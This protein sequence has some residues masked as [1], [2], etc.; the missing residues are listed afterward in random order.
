MITYSTQ[1]NLVIFFFLTPSFTE[2]S[3][4]SKQILG[5]L[6]K[7]VTKP[8]FTASSNSKFVAHKIK[9]ADFSNCGKP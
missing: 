3:I 8:K 5:F 6:K 2:I 4:K 9:I 7:T 1:M